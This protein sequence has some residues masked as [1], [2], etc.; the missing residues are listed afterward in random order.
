LSRSLGRWLIAA[1]F[2]WSLGVR[3]W[4]GNAELSSSRWWD[5]R[6]GLESISKIL[7]EGS[8]EPAN[9]YHPSL[10]Y[11]PQ[12]ALLGACDKRQIR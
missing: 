6:Y 4:F 2:V 1:F 7:K 12:A 9:G 8:F 3:V 5:E 10:S 11:L